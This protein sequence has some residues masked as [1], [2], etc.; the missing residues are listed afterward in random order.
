MVISGQ[1]AIYNTQTRSYEAFNHNL[2]GCNATNG[3]QTDGLTSGLISQHDFETSY[4][5]YYVNVGR[6]LDIEQSVP[7]SVSIIGT[8]YSAK[9]I[10]LYVF[11]EYR[12]NVG[13]NLLT[14]E[15]TQ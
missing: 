11:C 9:A 2:Y 14:G 3:G 6:C 1:N 5:Y 12:V 13:I 15:R 10:N 8:N 4:C 7:K